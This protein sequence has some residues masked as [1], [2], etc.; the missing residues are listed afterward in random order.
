MHTG[1]INVTASD[2]CSWTGVIYD[3]GISFTSDNTG[4]SG[5]GT[6]SYSVAANN[7]THPRTATL[8]IATRSFTLTHAALPV[9]ITGARVNRKSLLVFGEKFDI[10][11]VILLN[12]V[13]Q[14]TAND[15]HDPETL[16]ISKKTGKKIKAGDK[17]QVR[18]PN[19][20][21][22]QEFSFMGT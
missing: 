22:S 21:L 7:S 6:V 14:K 13:Q 12:G 11:A 3:A 15:D 20:T 10:G 4:S 18:N 17:L 2:E 5:N 8:L 19:G 1:S 16:L 9:A